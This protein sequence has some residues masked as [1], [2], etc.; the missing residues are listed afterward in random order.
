[1]GIIEIQRK[2]GCC[3]EMQRIRAVIAEAAQSGNVEVKENSAESACSVVQ[4]LMN[5][6]ALPTPV[7]EDCVGSALAIGQRMLESKRLDENRMGLESLCTLTD[8]SKVVAA[9]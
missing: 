1:M 9:D 3:I 6:T 8:S 4:K 2:Q 7:D 5:T